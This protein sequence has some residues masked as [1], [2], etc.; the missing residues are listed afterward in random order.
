MAL[1]EAGQVISVRF[2][3]FWLILAWCYR[4]VRRDRQEVIISTVETAAIESAWTQEKVEAIL[5][6]VQPDGTR[7]YFGV[8]RRGHPAMFRKVRD[9]WEQHHECSDQELALIDQLDG[10]IETYSEHL[11]G[12]D[13]VAME[14]DWCL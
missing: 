8:N 11:P 4:I 6:P 14:W 2:P 12:G 7:L 1:T 3:R 13:L 10:V 5:W 9:R